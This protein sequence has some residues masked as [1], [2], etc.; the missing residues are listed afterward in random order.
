MKKWKY[1]QNVTLKKCFIFE[2][3]KQ[4]RGRRV[5][6]KKKREDGR[7]KRKGASLELEK[8]SIYR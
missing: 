3:C 1:D 7:E 8:T 4:K 6:R 2:N 5:E